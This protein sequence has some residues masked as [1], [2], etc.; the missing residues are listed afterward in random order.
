MKT[1]SLFVLSRSL[2]LLLIAQHSA[3]ISADGV[4]RLRGQVE[5]QLAGVQ[6]GGLDQLLGCADDLAGD[7][8]LEGLGLEGQS[9]M[10]EA[11]GSLGQ[12]SGVVPVWNRQ[13]ITL[14][15]RFRGNE[16][17]TGR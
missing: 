7:V 17:L 12:D 11:L 16:A 9:D 13:E 6:A 8:A 1:N 15:Y 14:A 10:G 5:E 3:K 2:P 4:L